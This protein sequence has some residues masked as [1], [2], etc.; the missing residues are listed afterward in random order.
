VLFRSPSVTTREWEPEVIDEN[1]TLAVPMWWTS[2]VSPDC[3][4]EQPSAVAASRVPAR[5]VSGDGSSAATDDRPSAGAAVDAE[6]PRSRAPAGAIVPE[7]VVDGA[8][9]HP[10]TGVG[11]E[12]GLAFGGDEL[13]RVDLSNGESDT[14]RAGDGLAVSVLG[15]WTPIWSGDDLGIGFG[16][17]LGLRYKSVSA[18]NGNVSFTRV[19]AAVFAQLLPRLGDMWFLLVRGG[20]VKDLMTSL[21]GGGAAG[22]LNADLDSGFGAFGDAGVYWATNQHAG[23]GFTVRYTHLNLSYQGA[24]IAA[25]G[26]TIAFAGYLSK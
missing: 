25:D 10:G 12:L 2:A 26:F 23:L 15:S 8:E 3:A 19:P 20:V 22:G 21:S 4:R 17:S 14:I 7:A 24:P 18:S 9:F 16:G 1:V 11:L 13:A 6:G 5:E